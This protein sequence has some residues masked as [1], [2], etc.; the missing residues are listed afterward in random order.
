MLQIKAFLVALPAIFLLA[1]KAG[2]AIGATGTMLEVL[3]DF[4]TRFPRLARFGAGLAAVGRKLEAVGSDVPKFVEGGQALLA[5]LGK[6]FGMAMMFAL[7]CVLQVQLSG[8]AG[9]KPVVKG[10]DQAAIILCDVFFSE[11]PNAKG[12]SPAD[13]EKAFCSTAEQVAPFL[14][15]AKKAAGRGGA[16]RLSKV[17]Q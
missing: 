5:K 4:M 3:G 9:W 14:D 1:L 10:I 6:V 15:S 2:L 11:Q 12:L 17:P 16:I 7:L 8:C 13:V